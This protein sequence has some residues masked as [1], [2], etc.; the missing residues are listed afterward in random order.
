MLKRSGLLLAWAVAFASAAHAD[1]L[2]GLEMDVMDGDEAPDAMMQR[3]ELPDAAREGRR[4]TDP[5]SEARGRG[6]GSGREST[7]ALREA[8]GPP[9]DLGP[10]SERPGGERPVPETP[11]PDNRPDPPRP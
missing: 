3:I 1:A 2:D 4:P 9:A 6:A 5:A 7:E 8:L 10:P 11:S